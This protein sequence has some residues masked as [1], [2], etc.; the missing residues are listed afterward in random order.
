MFVKTTVT[1]RHRS[2]G[3]NT[4]R[5]FKDVSSRFLASLWESTACIKSSL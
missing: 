3:I 1:S 2:K 5:Q 4:L